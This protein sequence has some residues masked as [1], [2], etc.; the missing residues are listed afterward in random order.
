MEPKIY[1]CYHQKGESNFRD[2]ASINQQIASWSKIYMH[3]EMLLCQNYDLLFKSRDFHFALKDE[4]QSF[5]FPNRYF[6]VHVEKINK[7][8]CYANKHWEIILHAYY[9]WW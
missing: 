1:N 5:T 6:I 9:K 7:F 2:D 3:M 8:W 4:N